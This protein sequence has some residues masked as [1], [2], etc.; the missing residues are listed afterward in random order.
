[1]ISFLCKLFVWNIQFL[2]QLLN[3]H[4]LFDNFFVDFC[5]VYYSQY[6]LTKWFGS[7]V[8]LLDFTWLKVW[9]RLEF[10]FQSV[11]NLFRNVI[12]IEALQSPD[13][14]DV[15]DCLTNG[16]PVFFLLEKNAD[17]FQSEF[18]LSM[19]IL[20]HFNLW[21][22]ITIQGVE[23]FIRSVECRKGFTQNFIGLLFLF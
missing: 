19:R 23:G 12:N 5:K 2:V 8:N 14:T 4:F 1:M 17:T 21:N 9:I 20:V 10:V 16:L 15:R 11:F 3:D 18:N 6:P 22:V 13:E 7:E